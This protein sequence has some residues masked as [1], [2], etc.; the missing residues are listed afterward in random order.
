MLASSG[1]VPRA[2][3]RAFAALRGR[4]AAARPRP[5]SKC[6]AHTRR[7]PKFYCFFVF[8]I[9]FLAFFAF[10]GR[11]QRRSRSPS[12]ARATAPA[13]HCHPL[14]TGQAQQKQT[15]KARKKPLEH[16]SPLP[17]WERPLLALLRLWVRFRRGVSNPASRACLRSGRPPA[18]AAPANRTQKTPFRPMIRTKNNAL[19]REKAKKR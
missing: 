2:G 9:E 6:G 10:G 16:T 1:R 12:S 8:F 5:A 3:S 11:L 13:S 19:N 7:L 4:G 15:H 17:L 14:P 18:L